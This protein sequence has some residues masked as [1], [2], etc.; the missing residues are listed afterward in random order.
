MSKIKFDVLEESEDW[1]V[2]WEE[3]RNT[4]QDSMEEVVP[5][6]ENKRNKKWMTEKIMSLIGD[7]RRAKQS[8]NVERC[9][10]LDK[11]NKTGVC[12]CKG[13]MV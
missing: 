12:E 2:Y 10:A 9:K 8:Q 6:K 7:R 11:T 5:I 3:I 1:N 4:L 13:E